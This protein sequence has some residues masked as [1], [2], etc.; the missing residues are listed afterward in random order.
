MRWTHWLVS[1]QAVRPCRLTVVMIY[2]LGG[3]CFYGKRVRDDLNGSSGRPVLARGRHT[4]LRGLSFGLH[5][6]IS[7]DVSTE[8]KK[9]QKDTRDSNTRWRLDRKRVGI[10]EWVIKPS[11][12][13]VLYRAADSN[14]ACPPRPQDPG[15]PTYHASPSVDV[16]SI[17]VF[18]H[19]LA[20]ESRWYITSSVHFSA[21]KRVVGSTCAIIV[22]RGP[23][24]RP[25][26]RSHCGHHVADLAPT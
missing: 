9:E 2:R 17:N 16:Y 12:T 4:D 8:H 13:S 7:T 19:H 15:T 21:T 3:K 25:R 14:I 18:I 1:F 20:M 26:A 22:F 10:R 24:T 5:G 23:G 6:I 11:V